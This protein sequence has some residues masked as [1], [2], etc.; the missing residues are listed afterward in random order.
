ML[1][2][3][4]VKPGDYLVSRAVDTLLIR[5]NFI[6]SLSY[7]LYSMVATFSSYFDKQGPVMKGLNKNSYYVYIIHV[8]VIG[9]IALLLVH[10]AVPSLV[11][12]L[13]LTITAYVVC[14]V[15]IYGVRKIVCI[16]ADSSGK[17]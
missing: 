12:F 2:Y 16:I 13:I 7:L 3:S 6:L 17:R 11:K 10:T 4:L 5:L 8:I 14:N 9:G 1:I 15:I